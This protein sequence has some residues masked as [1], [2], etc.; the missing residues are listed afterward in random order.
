MAGSEA[1]I[2]YG[3]R[4]PEVGIHIKPVPIDVISRCT[5][6]CSELASPFRIGQSTEARM[7]SALPYLQHERRST[8]T[9]TDALHPCV[10]SEVHGIDTLVNAVSAICYCND[11]PQF[12]PVWNVSTTCC[13][14]TIQVSD[15]SFQDCRPVSDDP[16]LF[17]ACLC[18]GFN[19]SGWVPACYI[20][21]E[22]RQM[23]LGIRR[24]NRP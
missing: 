3:A 17:S 20:A 6:L 7:D 19:T 18:I 13:Q 12:T 1:R 23:S 9:I 24:T 15:G 11:S 2:P 16:R 21:K 8:D 10:V 4:H 22:L 5:H 14:H